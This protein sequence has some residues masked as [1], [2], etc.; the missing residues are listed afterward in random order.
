VPDVLVK[1]GDWPEDQ[2]IGRD[3]VEA[4]GGQVIRIPEVEGAS[5]TNIIDKVKKI[6]TN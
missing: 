3:V 5:T 6:P 4:H 1:G 2:I